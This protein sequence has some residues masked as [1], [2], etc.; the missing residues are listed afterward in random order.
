MAPGCHVGAGAQVD[1]GEPLPEK[2]AQ[3]I[4]QRREQ[5]VEAARPDMALADN[6]ERLRFW[7]KDTGGEAMIRPTAVEARNGYRIWLRYS[8]GAAGE[9]DLA[10]RGVFAAWN[11][12]RYFKK[13]HIAPHRAIAWDD[14]LELCRDALYMERTG[15]SFEELP[16]DIE[17]PVQDA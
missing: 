14:D 6:L 1:D 10:G 5:Q 13:V 4:A 15:K 9:V 8:D 3:L 12:P 7:R 2:M 16:A 17:T 11:E